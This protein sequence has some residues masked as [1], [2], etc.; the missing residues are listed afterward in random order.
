MTQKQKHK[1]K[2][3]KQKTRKQLKR[4]QIKM[5][6][7]VI[8]MFIFY[9]ICIYLA[10]TLY[11]RESS[12]DMG[13]NLDQYE[14]SFNVPNLMDQNIPV[15][16]EVTTSNEVEILVLNKDDYNENLDIIELRT[17]ALSESR[18]KATSFIFTKD[19][20]PGEYSIVSYAEDNDLEI[21]HDY[22]ITTYYLM[23]FLGLISLLFIVP[24]I[25]ALVWIF[26]LQRRKVDAPIDD[27]A[28]YDYHDEAQ[29]Y[30][31]DDRHY[32]NR[33]YAQDY[34]DD[35]YAGGRPR[36][37]HS[38][39]P[40]AHYEDSY[41]GY[42][43]YHD[44]DQNYPP[45]RQASQLGPHQHAPPPRPPK[46]ARQ[47]A[48]PPIE[49]WGQKPRA[50]PRPRPKPQPEPRADI[51]EEM[52]TTVPCKCGEIIIVADSTRP[53]R[54]KCPRCGRRGIL[55]GKQKAPDD[56]IFY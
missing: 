24:I 49:D 25:L 27:P 22:K 45:R 55:E 52:A 50:P 33:G 43:G 53:L 20:G 30:H 15:R 56:E 10:L 31:H 29:S 35:G 19:L 12:Y 13:R 4:S 1:Q 39:R 16:V 17:L 8:I 36:S 9:I 2:P 6:V 32:Q 37:H 23:P 38:A 51:D 34:Y 41:E 14:Q 11:T 42:D 47:R 48:P 21:G 3:R 18:G 46:P 5:V 28:H 7:F 54:I 26:V 40:D 44:Y